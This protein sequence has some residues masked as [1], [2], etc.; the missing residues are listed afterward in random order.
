VPG[1]LFSA[2][3]GVGLALTIGRLDS[4]IYTRADLESLLQRRCAGEIPSDQPRKRRRKRRSRAPALAYTRAI[5]AIVTE[6]LLLS[7]PRSRVIV[8]APSE[9]NP[10]AAK[11]VDDFAEALARVVP[12]VLL[13]DLDF[14]RRPAR[15]SL[16]QRALRRP[17]PA[18]RPDIFDVLAGRR[19]PQE[20]MERRGAPGPWVIPLNRPISDDPFSLLASGRLR[21]LLHELEDSFDAIVIGGPP[22]SDVHEAQI[23][24]TY[25]DAALLFVR[26]AASRTASVLSACAAASGALGLHSG[27]TRPRLWVALSDSPSKT[28][29]PAPLGVASG[30]RLHGQADYTEPEDEIRFPIR[31]GSIPSLKPDARGSFS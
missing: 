10:Q 3:F 26:S 19:T 16:L 23:I 7:L 20:V 2:I 15:R 11:I 30:L 14:S 25:A 17:T 28:R 9:A 12:R 18:A 31:S 8:A 21:R 1:T 13:I 4:R 29:R 27:T 24:A 22:M 6:T 5:E